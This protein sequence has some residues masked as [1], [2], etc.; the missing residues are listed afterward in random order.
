MTV[1]TAIYD[2]HHT[3]KLLDNR[4]TPKQVYKLLN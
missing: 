1:F 4:V 2:V 3:L